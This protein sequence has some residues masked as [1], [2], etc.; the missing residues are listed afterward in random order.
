MIGNSTR[1]TW[2]NLFTSYGNIEW[3]FIKISLVITIWPGLIYT[4]LTKTNQPYPIGICELINCASIT[5][6][7]VKYFV[8]G[9]LVILAL[10]YILEKKMLW[11]TCLIFILALII[12]AL[13]ESNGQKGRSGLLSLLFLAQAFAYFFKARNIHGNIEKNRIQFS[14]QMIAAVYTLAAISKIYTSGINWIVDS[15]NIALQIIK[16]YQYDYINTGEIGFSEYGMTIANWVGNHTLFMQILLGGSLLVELCSFVLM[17]NKKWAFYYSFLLLFMH[18]GIY[19]MLNITF[20]TV[21]NP[22]II[23]F[24]NPLYLIFLSLRSI[25]FLIKPDKVQLAE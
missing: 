14:V 24:M 12:F 13:Q 16:S 22:L 19:I 9:T 4:V 2:N 25:Y 8:V 3:L 23:F 18:I 17:L 15:P 5:G 11:T 1:P 20:P 6:D 10:L 21:S 7:V